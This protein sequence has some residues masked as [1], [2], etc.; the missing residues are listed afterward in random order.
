MIKGVAMAMFN[1]KEKKAK[2]EAKEKVQEERLIRREEMEPSVRKTRDEFLSDHY[3]GIQVF[4]VEKLDPDALSISKYFGA[5]AGTNEGGESALQ[6]LTKEKL[7]KQFSDDGNQEKARD[8]SDCYNQGSFCCTVI[9]GTRQIDLAMLDL[10]EE[11]VRQFP[12]ANAIIGCYIDISRSKY[13]RSTVVMGTAVKI[14]F[15]Q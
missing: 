3:S 4:T 15:T 13:S 6:T 11:A 9:D 10:K 5:V 14:E 1:N 8:F 2:R 12:D 7:I